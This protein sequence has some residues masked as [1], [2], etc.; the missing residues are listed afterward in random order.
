MDHLTLQNQRPPPSPD[1]TSSNNSDKEEV[2]THAT[3]ETA[4][5]SLNFASENNP[6]FGEYDIELLENKDVQP[7]DDVLMKF[8]PVAHKKSSLHYSLVMFKEGVNWRVSY[9]R[10]VDTP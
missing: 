4:K 2:R 1:L 10:K 3:R 6:T 9:C 8:E 5:H 7:G